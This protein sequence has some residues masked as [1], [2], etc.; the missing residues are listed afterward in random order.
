[1]PEKAK[2]VHSEKNISYTYFNTLHPYIFL[3]FQHP[4]GSYLG[5]SVLHP[6][7]KGDPD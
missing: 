6:Q 5:R 2:S 7:N 1:M 3:M 4:E